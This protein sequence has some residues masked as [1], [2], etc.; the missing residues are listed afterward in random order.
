[1]LTNSQPSTGI[2]LLI[3]RMV[4]AK[5]DTDA[6]VDTRPHK[7]TTT[8]RTAKTRNRGADH[9]MVIAR[10]VPIDIDQ[11]ALGPPKIRHHQGHRSDMT[12]GSLRRLQ[13]HQ[14]RSRGRPRSK[15]N[16]TRKERSAAVDASESVKMRR[17]ENANANANENGSRSGTWKENAGRRRRIKSVKQTAGMPKCERSV[18]D[19]V[20]ASP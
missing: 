6:G 3:T 13:A 20:G 12:A 19:H 9:H 14:Q 4:T 15:L 18:G 7:P 8:A 2:D 5:N 16:M 10:T 17:K 1:M 11:T